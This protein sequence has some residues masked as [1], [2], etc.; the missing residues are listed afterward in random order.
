MYKYLIFDLDDTILDFKS[1]EEKAL[2]KL[3]ELFGIEYSIPNINMYKKINNLIWNQIEQGI[4][5]KENGLNKR[6]KLFFKKLNIDYKDNINII[7]SSYLA[8]NSD[9]IKDACNVLNILRKE[10]YKIFAASNGITNIQLK[11]L[12]LSNLISYFDKIYISDS[13]GY[14][15]PHK[16]FFEHIFLDNPN[17]KINNT[18]FIG[19][20]INADIKGANNFNIDTVFYN[21]YLITPTIKPTYNIKQLN[22]LLNIL[23]IYP[24][25]NTY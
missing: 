6:F 17:L 16:K 13:I 3:F 8:D 2:Y 20:N 21:P 5:T 24:L 18:L 22:E 19:D 1:C 4:I 14:D 25:N 15:K 7:F 10:N 23:K 12:T 9:T 11:R